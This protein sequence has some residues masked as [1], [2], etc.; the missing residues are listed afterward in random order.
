ME[1]KISQLQVMDKM[2]KDNNRDIA[3]FPTIVNVTSVPQG[4][5]VGFGVVD[6]IGKDAQLQT[7]G[8]PGEYMFLCFSVKLSEFEKTKQ[9]LIDVQPAKSRFEEL[10]S[11]IDELCE[12]YSIDYLIGI[13]PGNV[14][15]L[16]EIGE[17]T[18]SAMGLLS[19]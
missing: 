15:L 9:S 18:A 2:V 14:G 12:K 16:C 8:L 7:L 3:F 19:Y 4:K 1:S 6:E 10:P 17:S 5:I 13:Q 11:K